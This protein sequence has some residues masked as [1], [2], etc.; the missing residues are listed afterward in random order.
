MSNTVDEFFSFEQ[1]ICEMFGYQ[2]DWKVFPIIDERENHWGLTKNET[3]VC[4]SPSAGNVGGGIDGNNCYSA[5]VYTYRHLDKW[6]YRIEKYT[7]ILMDTRCDGNIY[8]GIFDNSKEVKD[9]TDHYP[10]F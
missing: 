2:H 8:L 5:V 1:K 3:K 6:I 4:Y 7:M 10:E 9:F